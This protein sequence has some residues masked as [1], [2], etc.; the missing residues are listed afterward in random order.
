MRIILIRVSFI[1]SFLFL[2]FGDLFMMVGVE[3]EKEDD[4]LFFH[5]MVLVIH[6]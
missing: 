4:N 3:E 5:Q 1:D 6:I 2:S